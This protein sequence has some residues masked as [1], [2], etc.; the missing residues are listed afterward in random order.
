MLEFEGKIS[1]LSELDNLLNYFNRS[2]ASQSK[3]ETIEDL[4]NQV[5]LFWEKYTN[6]FENDGVV[7]NSNSFILDQMKLTSIGK[8]SR[9][10][11]SSLYSF[12]FYLYIKS[13]SYY[14]YIY[15]YSYMYSYVYTCIH[16]TP[17]FYQALDN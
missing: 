10:Y 9:K 3:D 1:R 14:S 8:Y 5:I 16:A 17:S 12:A 13:P 4:Y 7:Y 6:S 15:M 11:P 2:S